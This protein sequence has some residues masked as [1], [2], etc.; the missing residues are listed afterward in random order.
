ME[1]IQRLEQSVLYISSSLPPS[2]EQ[3]K[4]FR[5]ANP[6]VR[7]NLTLSAF[8]I[9]AISSQQIKITVYHQLDLKGWISFSISAYLSRLIPDCLGTMDSHGV[10]P[11][12]FAFG[13]AV[14]LVHR[15][16]NPA[17]KKLVIQYKTEQEWK[18]HYSSES[19]EDD[20]GNGLH[21][22]G[23]S[24]PSIGSLPI[25]SDAPKPRQRSIS[26]SFENSSYISSSMNRSHRASFMS[27]GFMLSSSP[28][29]GIRANFGGLSNSAPFHSSGITTSRSTSYLDSSAIYQ[30]RGNVDHCPDKSI[31][32]NVLG[33]KWTALHAIEIEA[34]S[35]HNDTGELHEGTSKSQINV[36]AKCYRISRPKMYMIEIGDSEFSTFDTHEM[37]TSMTRETA[38]SAKLLE[39]PEIQTIS[40]TLANQDLAD[41]NSQEQL[42]YLNG[43]KL[44]IMDYIGQNRRWSKSESATI[45]GKDYFDIDG[46]VFGDGMGVH[47]EFGDAIDMRS[48]E[49][50]KANDH[51]NHRQRDQ[52]M[53][54]SQNFGDAKE[55]LPFQ[56]PKPLRNARDTFFKAL[57]QDSLDDLDSKNAAVNGILTYQRDLADGSKVV[58]T[59]SNWDSCSIWD[60]KA[61]VDC[62]GI[63][64]QCRC[65][66]SLFSRVELNTN[67]HCVRTGD[68]T[69]DS[70]QVIGNLS[71]RCTVHSSYYKSTWRSRYVPCKECS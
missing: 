54:D 64:S 35:E 55:M 33:Q 6:Y 37:S 71:P 25:Q 24:M 40:I 51:G 65:L 28:T 48:G 45:R 23:R 2:K 60:V 30:Y 69:Y 44:L 50:T 29:S 17:E 20:S 47:D 42:V 8:H 3:P 32:L 34:F 53:F 14:Q 43:R 7:A 62:P 11:N 26:S 38:V 58:V 10:P 56:E 41:G 16:Y 63:C 18:K 27:P 46:D 22:F 9:E 68:P 61:I 4:S 52:K 15:A 67:R 12:I 31:Q 66:I 1:G 70:G 21:Q 19:D 57:N 39:G 5:P 36:S 13:S 59:E 49:S